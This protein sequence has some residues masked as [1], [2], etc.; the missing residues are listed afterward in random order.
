MLNILSLAL[1]GGDTI[2]IFVEG[3]DEAEASA[4]I[5]A[6]FKEELKHL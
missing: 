4:A 5:E 3:E 1:K 6:F 2:T